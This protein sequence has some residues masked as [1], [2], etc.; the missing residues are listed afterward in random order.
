MS[1]FDIL[2]TLTLE[3][4]MITRKMTPFSSSILCVNVV[5]TFQDRQNSI[6]WDPPFALCSGL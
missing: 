6:P 5:C 1:I 4:I 3:V 2:M